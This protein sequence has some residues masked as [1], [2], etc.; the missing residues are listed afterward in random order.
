MGVVAGQYIAAFTGTSKVHA[1][2][3]ETVSVQ[4]SFSIWRAENRN[5]AATLKDPTDYGS[6]QYE[7]RIEPSKISLRFLTYAWV[8][9]AVYVYSI[10]TP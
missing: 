10:R 9:N 7:M 3:E 2:I 8:T 4:S 1:F 6:S 5:P